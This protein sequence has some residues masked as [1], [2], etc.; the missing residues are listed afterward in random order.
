[1]QSAIRTL[2][3]RGLEMGHAQLQKGTETYHLPAWAA[4][5]LVVT[6]SLYFVASAVVS[7]VQLVVYD[8]QAS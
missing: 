1:M 6:F 7:R 3:A 4:V 5:M 8:Q 2:Y